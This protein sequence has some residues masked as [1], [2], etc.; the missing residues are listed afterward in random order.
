MRLQ[1]VFSSGPPSDLF[2]HDVKR[3]VLLKAEDG[4][5]MAAEGAVSDP[6]RTGLLAL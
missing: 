5:E 2:V 4:V 6:V 3:V 1:K